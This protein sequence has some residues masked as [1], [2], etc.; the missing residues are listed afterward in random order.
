MDFIKELWRGNA[1][2]PF[3]YWVVAVIGNSLFGITDRALDG[4][5]FYNAITAEKLT[6]LWGF[7]IVSTVYFLFSAVCVWRSATNY[8]GKPVWAILAKVVIVLGTIKSIG[9]FARSF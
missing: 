3:T 7:I 5:G 8:D 1:S 4:V 2:L 6:F 9:M